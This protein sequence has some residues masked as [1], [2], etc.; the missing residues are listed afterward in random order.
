[1]DGLQPAGTHSLGE[2]VNERGYTRGYTKQ[3]VRASL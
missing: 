2:S 1:M 3:A